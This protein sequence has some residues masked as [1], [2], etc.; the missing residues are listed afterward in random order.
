MLKREYIE[1][2][3]R[4]AEEFSDIAKIPGEL[5]SEPFP[6]KKYDI[7]GFF[8][9][10]IDCGGPDSTLKRLSTHELRASAFR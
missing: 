4:Y 3:N 6:I 8:N 2:S 7:G 9:W 10:H 1:H 5:S